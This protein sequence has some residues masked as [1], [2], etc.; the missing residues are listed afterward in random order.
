MSVCVCVVCC[1]HARAVYVMNVRVEA[2]RC[3]AAAAPWRGGSDCCRRVDQARASVPLLRGCGTLYKDDVFIIH[4]R[5]S[6][7]AR[8]REYARGLAKIIWAA[9]NWM[10]GNAVPVSS[11]RQN[12]M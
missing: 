12:N 7:V 10:G 11:H 1:S 5:R 2:R 8:T 3:T 6:E 9:A 4:F